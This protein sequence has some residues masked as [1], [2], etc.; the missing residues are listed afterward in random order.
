MSNTNVYRKYIQLDG[1]GPALCLNGS[2]SIFAFEAM[3]QKA[4]RLQGL[5]HR[6][7]DKLELLARGP[8]ADNDLEDLLVDLKAQLGRHNAMLSPPKRISIKV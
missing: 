6:A 7:T 5:L 4:T 2:D 3:E 1:K 8:A